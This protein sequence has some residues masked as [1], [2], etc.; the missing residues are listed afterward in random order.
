MDQSVILIVGVIILVLVYLYFAG[1][2]QDTFPHK[3]KQMFKLAE[4][5]EEDASTVIE[6]MCEDPGAIKNSNETLLKI[7]RVVQGKDEEKEKTNE[8]KLGSLGRN[9]ICIKGD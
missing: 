7:V 8:L 6:Y 3:Y 5:S 2:Y 1:V 4:M 9:C